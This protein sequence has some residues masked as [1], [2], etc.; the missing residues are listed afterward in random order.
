[1]TA[2]VVIYGTNTCGYCGA[3][4][5][6]LTRK[7]VAYEDILVNNEPELRREMVHKSGRTAVPQIFVGDRHIGGYDELAALD[8][9]GELDRILGGK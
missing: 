2:A 4:R 9:S 3:A 1:M 8:A 5:M 6:L 7:G